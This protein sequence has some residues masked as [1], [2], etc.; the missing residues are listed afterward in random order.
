MLSRDVE[1]HLHG[2]D[3]TCNHSDVET[4]QCLTSVCES[5]CQSSYLRRTP[6]CNLHPTK[7]GEKPD[8]MNSD[9]LHSG[10]AERIIH[11]PTAGPQPKI[12]ELTAPR[13]GELMVMVGMASG[14]EKERQ[15]GGGDL[16]GS[17]D[18][19]GGAGAADID[20]PLKP[21]TFYAP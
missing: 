4:H 18:G 2:L 21:M 13:A 9:S 8:L 15:L 1:L 14:A 6:E 10:L 12:V 20:D 17:G 16:G 3:S 11:P 5:P 19:G 7:G